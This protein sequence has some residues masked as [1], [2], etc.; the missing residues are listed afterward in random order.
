MGSYLRKM[1]PNG[2]KVG[3]VSASSRRITENIFLTGQKA[4]TKGAA[5][6]F[7][8][9]KE[10]VNSKQAGIK[11]DDVNPELLSKDVQFAKQ[12]ESWLIWS[13]LRIEGR[14]SPGPIFRQHV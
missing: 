4:R 1:N 13:S 12:H 3:P 10:E 6:A 7:C 5:V 2:F 8:W 9:H 11:M 14:R